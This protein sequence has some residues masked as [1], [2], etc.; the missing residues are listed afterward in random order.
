MTGAVADGVTGRIIGVVGPSGVGKDTVMGALASARPHLHIQKRVITRE[1]DL[2]GED[3]RSISAQSFA[4]QE[5]QG[6]F[7][8]SWGAHDLFYG[9]PEEIHERAARGQ[10][11][12]V[13]LSRNVLEQAN[14]CFERFSV[15]S[16]TAPRSVLA[17]RLAARGRE[18]ETDIL[19][20]LARVVPQQFAG[21]DVLE[22]SN[23]RPISEVVAEIEDFYFAPSGKR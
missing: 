17:A 7:A 4:E 12:L 3:F 22:V 2:G 5:A 21:L 1:A 15:L 20:R 6:A 18:S 19:K 23:D 16:L 13:N 9:I 10:D 11:V 14:T 8:L